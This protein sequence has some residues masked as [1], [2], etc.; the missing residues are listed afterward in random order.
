MKNPFRFLKKSSKNTMDE[1]KPVAEAAVGEDTVGE[2]APVQEEPEASDDG[3][4]EWLRTAQRGGIERRERNDIYETYSVYGVDGQGRLTCRLYHRYPEHERDFGLS[5]SRTTDFDAFNARLLAEL[6]RGVIKSGDYHACIEKAEQLCG[7]EKAEGTAY[8]GFSEDEAAVL[9]GFC[10]SADTLTDKEYRTGDGIFRCSC[11]S[12]VGDEALSLWFRRPLPHD[13]L[14][15]DV[16]GVSR[17]E[18]GGYDI[19][20]MWIM[21][22]YNRI[23]ERCKGC[24]VMKMTYDWSANRE[25]VYLMTLE[26]FD[27]IGGTLLLAAADVSVF[28]RFGFYALDFSKKARL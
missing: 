27:G 13:A 24:K 16:A 7:I 11:R 26:D 19:E 9:R 6:D 22:V 18:I 23:S 17:T 5:Y 1:L 15:A 20:S 21:G 10:E 12:V 3:F 8:V 28:S 25:T 2:D 14:Y 4:V